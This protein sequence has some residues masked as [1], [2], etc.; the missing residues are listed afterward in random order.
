MPC[1]SGKLAY[2]RKG[3]RRAA[4]GLRRRTGKEAWAY[5]CR[6]C[7]EWH[8]TSTSNPE[9]TRRREAFKPRRASPA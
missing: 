5:P 4:K 1:A 2:T 8:I 9:I 6:D 3:A 7:D